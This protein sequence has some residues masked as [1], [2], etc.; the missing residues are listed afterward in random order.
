MTTTTNYGLEKPVIGGDTDTWGNKSNDNWDA[1]DQLIKNNESAIEELDTAVDQNKADKSVVITAG[2]G[3][4]GGGNL[5]ESRE[6]ALGTPSTITAQTTNSTTGTSHTH[7]I[8]LGPADVGAPPVSRQ[9]IAGNG[10]TG[11][12]SLAANVPL[13][14]GTPSKLTPST[15]NSVTAQS[16]THEVFGLVPAGGIIMW[17]GAINTVPAGWALCN[18]QN[19]TPDLRDRFVVGAGST[20]NPGNTGGSKD[21]IV[22]AHTHSASTGSSGNHSHTGSTNT[23]GNHEH[24]ALSSGGRANC[25]VNSST[26]G[27]R[28]HGFADNNACGQDTRQN[29]LIQGTN[30]VANVARTNPSGDHS[31]TVSTN[32][33]G[34]HSHS[35]SVASTGSSGN[36]AN[37]PPYLALAFIMKLPE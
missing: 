9:I 12:G 19:G 36:N 21:A 34:A 26:Y 4:T 32:T 33:T 24:F 35:V 8:T 30:T 16:H 2:N 25:L 15:T 17:S 7:T 31:H 22:V 5:S 29:A 6:V 3:L 27:R 20:Y 14:L 18:G 23:T 28:N 1:V 11:G 10:L 37:L 13:V